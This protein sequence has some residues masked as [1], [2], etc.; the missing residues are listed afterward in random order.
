MS[1]ADHVPDG[2]T[3]DTLPPPPPWAFYECCSDDPGCV[4]AGPHEV[5]GAPGRHLLVVPGG[6]DWPWA[7]P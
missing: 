3:A 1:Q 7:R 2:M 5:H 6:P 4:M